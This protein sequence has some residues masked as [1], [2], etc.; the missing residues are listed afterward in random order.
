MIAD[1]WYKNAVIYSLDVETF[2]D[3]DGDGIGDFEGLCRRLDYLAS[4]GIDAI[5][6]A[7]FQPSPDRDDG[8]DIAD[9]YGVDARYGNSGDFVEFMHQAKRRGLRVVLDLVV[10][11]VSDK[12]PWFQEARRDPDSKYR[13]WFVWSKKRPKHW[14]KGM[15]F[16][17]H[18]LATWTKDEVA[19]LWFYHRF[20][21]FQPD[22]NSANPAVQ[23]EI[24]RVVA[25]WIE[26]GVAGFRI[27]AVPF[28][29][30]VA[31]AVSEDWAQDFDY[32]YD[33]RRQAQLRRG[34]AVLLG[35]ANLP[36]GG[37]T[38]F[39]GRRGEGLQMMF[40]FWANQHLYYS[41]ATHDARPL[42]DALRA[43][44]NIPEVCQWAHF[45]RNHDEL[46][47]GRLTE[48]Q[49]EV[50]YARFA[51]DE[52]MRLYDRGIRRR[53]APMLGNRAQLELA[54]SLAFALPGASVLRYGDEIG[55]GDDLRLPGRDAVRTPMQW[56]NERNGGFSLADALAHP[57]I[58]D[59]IYGYPRVNVA[60]QQREPGS[61]L[62]WFRGMIRLRKQ[63]PEIGWGDWKILATRSPHVLA[64]EYQ[65]RGSALVIVHNFDAQSRQVRIK[66]TVTGSDTL[67]DLRVEEDSH[68]DASGRHSIV[69]EPFGYRW[70]RVRS[71]DF[72]SRSSPL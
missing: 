24:R 18:Q 69:L 39:F 51:P 59:G 20:F 64:I 22:L 12:H 58:D 27:D 33:L 48:E 72:A 29:I 44:R 47:L 31:D 28:L 4:L 52:H 3:A 9:F 8:Y 2:M 61:L 49:R 56:S 41:L 65:W 66:P 17:G 26:L 37:E 55:M 34:D 53:L 70:F 45:L 60:D 46:D 57:V 71:L 40:N 35:E 36:P 43:T 62:N 67:V 63:C 6:L 10:N 21:E 7:P 13:D 68:A 54:Q 32:L 30:E 5:W 14:N 25:Y 42:A 16:P 19:G 38:P 1:L 23:E 15:V 11:H 50:A